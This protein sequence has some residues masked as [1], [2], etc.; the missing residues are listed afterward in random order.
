MYTKA[1]PYGLKRAIGQGKYNSAVPVKKADR[2]KPN[3]WY[4]CGYWMK[5][6][7]VLEVNYQTIQGRLY[8]KDVTVQWED[9]KVGT[10]S[11]AL[12]VG[13]DYKLYL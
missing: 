13:H 2:Y 7:K 3:Q 9:G 11:T 4:W 12:D 10:H 6:Y 5:A 8:L 1:L